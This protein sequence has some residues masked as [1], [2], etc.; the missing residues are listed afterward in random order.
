MNTEIL[1]ISVFIGHVHRTHAYQN[2]Y[3]FVPIIVCIVISNLNYLGQIGT[4]DL[5]QS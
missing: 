5:C 2:L 3:F 4:E 1:C